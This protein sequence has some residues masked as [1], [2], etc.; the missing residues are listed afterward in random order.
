MQAIGK[1]AVYIELRKQGINAIR[2][3]ERIVPIVNAGFK[4]LRSRDWAVIC[5]AILIC[6][7]LIAAPIYYYFS[8]LDMEGDSKQDEANIV[9]AFTGLEH[10]SEKYDQLMSA[11]EAERVSYLST[12]ADIDIELLT[13]YAILEVAGDASLFVSEFERWQNAINSARLSVK[14]IFGTRYAELELE[15]AADSIEAQGVYGRIMS[16]LD[17]EDERL[18]T[19]AITFDFLN[20][21]KGSWRVKKGRLEWFDKEKSRE[22]DQISRIGVSDFKRWKSDC[23]EVMRMALGELNESNEEIEE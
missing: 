20:G 18:T 19:C 8:S 1:D 10:H 13:N 12:F 23:D 21:C 22:Y 14:K 7:V 5:G 9:N 4:G 6:G 17:A 16:E 11:L 2:V 3:E 15:C